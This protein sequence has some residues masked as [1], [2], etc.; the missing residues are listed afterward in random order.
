MT[1]WLKMN[2]SAQNKGVEDRDARLCGTS[3]LNHIRSIYTL[4]VI[5]GMDWINHNRA[6]ASHT[7]IAAKARLVR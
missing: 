3:S 6:H 5:Q 2:T 1:G 7:C 4:D